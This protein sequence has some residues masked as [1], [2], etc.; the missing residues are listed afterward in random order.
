V[1]APAAPQQRGKLPLGCNA[2]KFESFKIAPA[3]PATATGTVAVQP[4]AAA[5]AHPK[6]AGSGLG[7]IANAAS[8]TNKQAA[9]AAAQTNE[10]RAK[11]QRVLLRVK[12]NIHVAVQ[13]KQSTIEATTLSV[14]NQG[15]TIVLKQGLPTSTKL[16]LEHLG[17]KEKINCRVAKASR[18]MPEGFHIPLEFDAPAPNFWGIAF[19]PADWKPHDDM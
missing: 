6:P 10:Q 19:P 14:Y 9:Q 18:E 12:A 3:K 1:C 4:P 17:T 11:S 13:G 7:A 15:A 2:L 16:V 5:P 8:A